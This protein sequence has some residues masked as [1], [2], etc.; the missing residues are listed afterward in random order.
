[1]IQK[2]KTNEYTR[3]QPHM[4]N[5]RTFLAW[6]RTSIAIMGFGFVVEKF[7]LFMMKFT[8]LLTQ[9]G[10]KREK[11]EG[12][13]HYSSSTGI[14]LIAIG[15]VITLVAFVK[16]VNTERQIKNEIYLRSIFVDFMLTIVIIVIAILFTIHLFE[17]KV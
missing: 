3:A 4:A 13:Q 5:E 17:S 8:E 9:L 7:G 11:V 2:D 16:Y 14:F 6:I 15:A 10:G 12:V 1:M